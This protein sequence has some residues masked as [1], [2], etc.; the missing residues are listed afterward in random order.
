MTNH[1][2]GKSAC[3]NCQGVTWWATLVVAVIAVPC[4]GIIAA[5]MW[6]SKGLGEIIVFV[7]ACWISTWLGMRLMRNPKM[8]KTFDVNENP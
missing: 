8:S 5:M 6:G 7:G 1:A 4:F 3:G 2:D